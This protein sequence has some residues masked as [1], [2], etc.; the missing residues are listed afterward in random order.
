MKVLFRTVAALFVAIGLFL[1]YA[2][3][4]A[5]A[6]EGGARPGVAVG[7]VIAAIVLGFLAV[8]LWGAAAKRGG[9]D[10]VQA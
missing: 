6:S 9:S 8:R 5:L 1:L 10:T 3:V 7:Y 4:N 2:V